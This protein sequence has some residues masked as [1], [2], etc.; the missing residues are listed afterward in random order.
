MNSIVLIQSQFLFTVGEEEPN[1]GPVVK[2]WDLKQWE[3]KNEPFCKVLSRVSVRRAKTTPPLAIS[4]AAAQT[5]DLVCVGESFWRF[6]DM[7][8]SLL[9]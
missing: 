5:M 7:D 9:K 3:H 8:Q 4:I 6:Y 2:L 1:V